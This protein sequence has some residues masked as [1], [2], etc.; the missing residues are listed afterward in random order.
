MAN[1]LKVKHNKTIA[2]E[3]TGTY[4]QNLYAV[5]ITDTG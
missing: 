1:W 2:M 5:L 4:W 3:S